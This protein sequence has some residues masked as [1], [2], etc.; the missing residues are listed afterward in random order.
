[1][2]ERDNKGA[3]IN[4]ERPPLKPSSFPF[5]D[6]TPLRTLLTREL[7]DVMTGNRRVAEAEATIWAE[8]TRTFDL[9][10]PLHQVI[11]PALAVNPRKKI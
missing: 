11:T 1:M 5:P 10:K 4:P 2:T 3:F 9:P 7:V 8:I 6:T